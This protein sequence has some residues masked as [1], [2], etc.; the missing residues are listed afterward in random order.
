MNMGY[1]DNIVVIVLIKILWDFFSGWVEYSL[2]NV[3]F[4]GCLI[5]YTAVV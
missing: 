4:K 3:Y 1:G 2:N 5:E